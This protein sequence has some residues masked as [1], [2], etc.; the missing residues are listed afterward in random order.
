MADDG[1]SA[2]GMSNVVQNAAAAVGGIGVEGAGDIEDEA[3]PAVAVV[4]IGVGAD[5]VDVESVGAFAGGEGT[6][7]DDEAGG[8]V[9]CDA[10]SV[11]VE[12]A[13]GVGEAGGIAVVAAV[14]AIKDVGGTVDIAFT[15]GG[16]TGVEGAG[17]AVAVAGAAFDD[18]VGVVQGASS[19][20]D[21][22]V[23]AR[24]A[25]AVAPFDVDVGGIRLASA[26]SH[27]IATVTVGAHALSKV[28]VIVGDLKRWG[29][30]VCA[31]CI[32]EKG[33]SGAGLGNSKGWGNP[34]GT[35]GRVRAGPGT[36]QDSATRQL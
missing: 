26:V 7:S 27:V 5:G 1:V 30:C 9:T 32:R 28:F 21:V 12:H 18:G 17:H 13:G 6:G 34:R 31:K 35:R 3:A 36:G 20:G 14:V 22:G 24:G 4:V 15:A 8:V 2:G 16:G 11:G 29:E 23:V 19:V 25:L 10:V 33:V